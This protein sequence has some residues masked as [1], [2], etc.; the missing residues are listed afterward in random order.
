MMLNHVSVHSTVIRCFPFDIFLMNLLISCWWNCLFVVR[1]MQQRCCEK[2][3]LWLLFPLA[4]KSM[5]TK[6]LEDA[7]CPPELIRYD[8]LW[9]RSGPHSLLCSSCKSFQPSH[10]SP[11]SS[12]AYLP[13]FSSYFIFK[14]YFLQIHNLTGWFYSVYARIGVNRFTHSTYAQWTW[15]GVWYSFSI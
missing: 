6:F 11:S 8:G 2:I 12:P 13:L 14:E 7:A 10:V 3:V 4:R 15:T 1:V 5:E 9:G